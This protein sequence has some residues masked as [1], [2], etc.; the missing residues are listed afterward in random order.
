MARSAGISPNSTHITALTTDGEAKARRS[1][2]RSIGR[3]APTAR[4]GGGPAAPTRTSSRPS[5]TAI[6][7]STID[8][9]RSC[10]T[11]RQ[12]PA[13]SA[14]RVAISL[15][16]LGPRQQQRRDVQA[17]EQQHR[18]E[19]HQEPQPPLVASRRPLSPPLAR[20]RRQAVSRATRSANA[21]S[22]AARAPSR[23][24]LTRRSV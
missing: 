23:V 13:P 2:A 8:S 19:Q 17:G 10:R 14:R 20:T 1:G 21:F 22:G 11:I 5:D 15:A 6:P 12:R 3:S 7:A 9:V 18:A 16:R 24:D 4:S